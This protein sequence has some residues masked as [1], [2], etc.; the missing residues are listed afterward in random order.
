[1][2]T[3]MVQRVV[4]RYTKNANAGINSL[5]GMDKRAG[6]RRI[7]TVIGNAHLNGIFRD[8]HWTPIQK[9]L[10]DFVDEGIPVVIRSSNY[11][12]DNRGT[13]ISKTWNFQVDWK[14]P[15]GQPVTAYGRI[16]A[17]GAGSVDDPMEAYDVVAYAN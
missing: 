2:T 15:R 4:A 11:D 6:L 7:N 16:V 12:T 13:P 10:K 8:S 9:L 17:A 14:G 1:M 5:D 3:T